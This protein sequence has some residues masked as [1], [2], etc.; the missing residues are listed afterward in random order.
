MIIML[1]LCVCVCVC[2]HCWGELVCFDGTLC[3]QTQREKGKEGR[4]VKVADDL[5]SYRGQGGR[6][7]S[8]LC[9]CCISSF[10]SLIDLVDRAGY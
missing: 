7:C 1:C 4:P 3:L 8:L 6:R 5:A 10:F 9:V 2:P